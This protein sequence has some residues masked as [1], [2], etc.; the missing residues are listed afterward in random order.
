MHID[1]HRHFIKHL[2]RL[3][4]SIQEKVEVAVGRFKDDPYDV[5]LKNHAL[6]GSLVGRR[7]IW[8]TGD[9]RI[10]FVEHKGYTLVLFLDVGTHAQVYGE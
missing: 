1:Y 3:P 8:V 10:I 6:L 2:K 9:V 4:V 5:R 7:A